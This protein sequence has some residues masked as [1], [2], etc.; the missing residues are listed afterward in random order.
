VFASIAV[1]MREMGV[2]VSLVARLLSL[3]RIL[4]GKILASFAIGTRRKCGVWS[5]RAF[6]SK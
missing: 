5:R 6:L 4:G 3:N 1:A 2:P